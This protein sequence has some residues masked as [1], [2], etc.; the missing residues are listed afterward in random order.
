MRTIWGDGCSSLLE[1][2]MRNR[3]EAVCESPGSSLAT[4]AGDNDERVAHLIRLNAHR[5]ECARLSSASS[6]QLSLWTGP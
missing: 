3:Q 5:R 1:A 6:Q 4:D 2:A